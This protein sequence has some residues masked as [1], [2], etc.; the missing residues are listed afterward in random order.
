MVFT[1]AVFFR[2]A[3]SLARPDERENDM[4]VMTGW[5][6]FKDL[7]AAQ[8]EV[9]RAGWGHARRHD[10][11]TIQ[12][13]RHRR[14][15]TLPDHVRAGQVEATAQDGV[16]QVLVPQAPDVQAKRIPVRPGQLG[17]AVP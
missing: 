14:S 8:D 16:L 10:Q 6:L 4:T 3:G 13:E 2:V 12:G 17:A 15:I 1:R 7:R 11:Q 9:M 5:D